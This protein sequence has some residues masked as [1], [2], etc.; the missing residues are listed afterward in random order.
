[1]GDFE[2]T[3]ETNDFNK[4]CSNITVKKKQLRFRESGL[5][6]KMGHMPRSTLNKELFANFRIDF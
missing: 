2:T 3:F 4:L 5:A 6:F 1:M